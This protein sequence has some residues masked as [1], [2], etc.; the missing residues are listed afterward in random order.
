MRKEGSKK[1]KAEAC[2]VRKYNKRNHDFFKL[3]NIENT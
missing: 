3:T 2:D 1:P